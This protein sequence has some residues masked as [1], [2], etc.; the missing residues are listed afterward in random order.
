MHQINEEQNIDIF[1]QLNLFLTAISL[2]DIG[3]YGLIK[4][5]RH[6]NMW[7]LLFLVPAASCA[8]FPARPTS[9]KRTIVFPRP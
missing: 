9:L 2:T 4:M 7:H 6:L 5:I 8:R 3:Y 1:I